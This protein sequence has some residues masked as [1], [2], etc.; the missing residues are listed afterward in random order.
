MSLISDVTLNLTSTIND[1]YDEYEI[2]IDSFV[3]CMNGCN[4]TEK[5]IENVLDKVEN[6]FDSEIDVNI[7]NYIEEKKENINIFV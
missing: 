6:E 2:I 3:N 5:Q 4:M 1:N 7:I